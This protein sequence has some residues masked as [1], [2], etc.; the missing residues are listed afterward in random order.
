MTIKG[1]TF[2]RIFGGNEIDIRPQGSAELSFG[3]NRSTRDNPA[4]PAN[5]RSTTTFDFDQQIQLNVV[6]HIG[7]KLK[8]STSYN[9]E[10]TFDFENQMKLE[11]TGYEDEIIQKIEAGNVSLPLKGQLITGSQ[12]L[13]GIKTELRFNWTAKL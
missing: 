13:F 1:E 6:G 4:L 2:D 9:T 5:Q 10:A 3:I 12:T 7:E 11:Y 8:I